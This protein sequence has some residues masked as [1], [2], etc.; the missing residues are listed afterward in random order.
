M[1]IKAAVYTR[2]VKTADA[3]G[4]TMFYFLKFCLVIL[5]SVRLKE[6][7]LACKTCLK[8]VLLICAV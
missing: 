6:T 3:E 7:Y 2:M 1:G 5:A 4:L 8:I